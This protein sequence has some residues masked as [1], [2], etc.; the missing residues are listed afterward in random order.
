MWSRLNRSALALL[1]AACGAPEPAPENYHAL[2]D[3]P[4]SVCIQMATSACIEERWNGEYRSV[5]S[6]VWRGPEACELLVHYCEEFARVAM[7]ER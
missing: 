7:E 4:Q 6:C 5:L 1:L 2:C 3:I